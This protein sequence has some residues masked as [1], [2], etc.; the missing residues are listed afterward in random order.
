MRPQKRRLRLAT[1]IIFDDTEEVLVTCSNF[2]ISGHDLL[3]D[4]AER[5]RH[6]RGF[7]RALVHDS[8]DGLTVNFGNDYP[9]GVTINGLNSLA[10][11][12]DIK[13]TISHDDELS[14]NVA[15]G[16]LDKPARG[17]VRAPEVVSLGE[18][19]KVLRRQMALLEAEVARLSGKG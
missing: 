19:V 15:A 7:R 18:V 12:G 8:S 13:F 14:G 6:G 4:A 11:G 10:V 9:G 5:R 17:F 16:T 1:D 3:L 2:K